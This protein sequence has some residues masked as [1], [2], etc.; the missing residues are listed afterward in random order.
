M[1]LASVCNYGNHLSTVSREVLNLSLEFYYI[2]YGLTNI[3][4]KSLCLILHL[5]NSCHLAYNHMKFKNKNCTMCVWQKLH[6]VLE[7]SLEACLKSENA[8]LMVWLRKW[9]IS[10][11]KVNL[12]K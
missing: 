7:T 10:I 9:I 1:V 5:S 8:I 2:V 12:L 3:Y 6:V 4:E 11:L